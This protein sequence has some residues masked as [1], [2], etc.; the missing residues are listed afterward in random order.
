MS[1]QPLEPVEGNET[2]H[3]IVEP[4]L[5]EPDEAHP[6]LDVAGAELDEPEGMQP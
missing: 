2:T 1:T 3:A 5:T 6:A 4:D